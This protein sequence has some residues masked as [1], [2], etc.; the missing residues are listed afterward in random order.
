[1]DRIPRVI[2][3]RRHQQ[4][5]SSVN[6]QIRGAGG[7]VR[8]LIPNPAGIGGLNERRGRAVVPVPNQPR[9]PEA[10]RRDPHRIRNAMRG[11]PLNTPTMTPPPPRPRTTRSQANRKSKIPKSVPKRSQ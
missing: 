8:R 11:R 2:Q 10:I 1:M 9:T 7:D 4:R 3:F 6:R 5:Q